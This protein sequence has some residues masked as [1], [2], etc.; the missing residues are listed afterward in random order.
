MQSIMQLKGEMFGLMSIGFLF[1]ILKVHFFSAV[2]RYSIHKLVQQP[3][4]PIGSGGHAHLW[5]V[6][7][8]MSDY[9]G[10]SHVKICFFQK[11]HFQS[12]AILRRSNSMV[13]PIDSCQT[14]SSDFRSRNDNAV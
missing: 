6:E 9:L 12:S 11:F 14:L 10:K 7:I 8:I 1:F 4:V 5:F 2:I 13:V 3:R